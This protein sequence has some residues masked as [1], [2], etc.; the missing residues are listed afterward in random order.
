MHASI[1][2]LATSA[3]AAGLALGASATATANGNGVDPFFNNPDNWENGGMYS[4]T[5]VEYSDG[6]KSI[7]VPAGAAFLAVKAGKDVT[8]VY[9]SYEPATFE[10]DISFVI[11]CTFVGQPY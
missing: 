8:Q 7:S 9:P 2:L 5:K 1:R 3:A 4:C 11:T 10:K 6:T